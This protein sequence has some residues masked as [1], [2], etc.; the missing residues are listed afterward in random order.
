MVLNFKRFLIKNN[1]FLRGQK[2][3]F[4]THFERYIYF[5]N[6]TLKFHRQIPKI[7]NTSLKLSEL[8]LSKL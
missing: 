6:V 7:V 4:F 2:S 8:Q 5:R 3:I 1:L